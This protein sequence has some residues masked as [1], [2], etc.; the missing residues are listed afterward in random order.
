LRPG[1]FDAIV[2]VPP[3]DLPARVEIFKVHT[4]KMPLAED[5]N[6]SILAEMTDG[7]SGA[8]IEGLCREAAMTAVR[9]DWKAKPVTMKHFEL[10][11]KETRPSLSPKDIER[12]A[13]IAESVKKRQPQESKVLP[14]YL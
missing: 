7:Y 4:K 3:P 12:F 6:V 2:F 1:R 10:A 5:V 11:L 13:A 9:A 14:G 8:D